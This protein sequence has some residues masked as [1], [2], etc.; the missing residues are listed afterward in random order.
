M[1]ARP[2]AWP[3]YALLAATATAALLV[4]LGRSGRPPDSTAYPAPFPEDSGADRPAAVALPVEQRGEG[5]G[6]PDRLEAGMWRV[7]RDGVEVHV[8]YATA[9]GDRLVI[10]LTVLNRNETALA[11]ADWAGSDEVTLRGADGKA[12]PLRPIPADRLRSIREWEARQ[13][14]PVFLYGAGPVTRERGRVATLEFDPAAAGAGEFL[15]LD[16]AGGPVGFADPILFRIPTG[17]LLQP[18]LGGP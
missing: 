12:Y 8:N 15:D 1:Q 9:F 4:F 16:L 7:V 10:S 6:H 17:M 3:W 5:R 13:P 2:P 18:P 14:D 11:F